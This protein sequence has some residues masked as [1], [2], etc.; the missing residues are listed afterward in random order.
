MHIF[1]PKFNFYQYI[2]SK[3][4]VT[5]CSSIRPELTPI[6]FKSLVYLNLLYLELEAVRVSFEGHLAGGANV[7]ELVYYHRRSGSADGTISFIYRN[8][9]LRRVTILYEKS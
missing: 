3:I 4:R 7:D 1:T 2:L 5:N 6:E 8:N 9:S